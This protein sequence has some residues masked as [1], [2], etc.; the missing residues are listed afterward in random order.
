MSANCRHC[1]KSKIH[2]ERPNLPAPG[3]HPA[4]RRI[5]FIAT[6]EE[7]T[8][9]ARGYITS[10]ECEQG[11]QFLRRECCDVAFKCVAGA[12]VRINFILEP[13]PQRPLDFLQSLS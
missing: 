10:I 9:K 6:G 13:R 1:M 8:Y 11:F 2:A 7:Q 12:K 5:S 3:T 4:V